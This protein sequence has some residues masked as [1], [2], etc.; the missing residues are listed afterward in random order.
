MCKM[1]LGDLE[2]IDVYERWIDEMADGED[3]PLKKYLCIELNKDCKGGGQ[4]AAANKRCTDCKTFSTVATSADII[5]CFFFQ[6]D[7]WGDFGKKPSKDDGFG[8]F[9]E[10]K[11]KDDGKDD[12]D[13]KG[14]EEL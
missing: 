1:F 6:D 4:K 7:P 11:Q 12:E 2:E 10:K 9:I 8:N 3:E 13:K 14:K 5:F